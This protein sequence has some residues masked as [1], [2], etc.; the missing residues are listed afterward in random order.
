MKDLCLDTL[1]GGAI[2]FAVLFIFL[3][4]I[5]V[6]TLHKEVKVTHEEIDLEAVTPVHIYIKDCGFKTLGLKEHYKL[7]EVE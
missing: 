3:Y 2:G 4:S 7:C 6:V 5:N 1:I